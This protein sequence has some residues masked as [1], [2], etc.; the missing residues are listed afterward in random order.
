MFCLQYIVCACLVVD[1]GCGIHV[2]N[3]ERSAVLVFI[4]NAASQSGRLVLL[5]LP[6]GQ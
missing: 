3:D 6:E 5:V 1:G 4:Y 2:F